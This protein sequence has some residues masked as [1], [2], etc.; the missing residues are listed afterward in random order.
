MDHRPYQ[1]NPAC[2]TSGTGTIDDL[3]RSEAWSFPIN[4]YLAMFDIFKII[5][6]AYC[7]IWCHC[8]TCPKTGN[9]N[10]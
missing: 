1:V 3:F 10:D 9:S 2:C 8:C 6:H 7:G 4:T 5:I